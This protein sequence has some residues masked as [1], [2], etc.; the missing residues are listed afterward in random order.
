MSRLDSAT[1]PLIVSLLN[2]DVPTLTPREQRILARWVIVKTLAGEFLPETKRM[3]P[4]D[5]YRALY[6][7]KDTGKV[8]DGFEVWI[9]RV[10]APALSAGL[11]RKSMT[12]TIG[13]NPVDPSPV[14][15]TAVL[16]TYSLGQLA[17]QIL[18]FD[19]EFPGGL[20]HYDPLARCVRRIYPKP[21]RFTWPPGEISLSYPAGLRAWAKTQIGPPK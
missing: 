13:R 15:T 10:D 5:R 21:R 18:G 2:D 7:T 19:K 14:K 11:E 16:A 1:Q 20:E 17:L 8:P 12:L 6:D 9:A 3:V 4:L